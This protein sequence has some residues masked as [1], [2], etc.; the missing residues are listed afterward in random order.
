MT[1]SFVELLASVIFFC[2]IIHTFLVGKFIKLAEQ[3]RE[4]SIQENL[5][6]FFAE[7]EAVFGIWSALFLIIMCF[8]SG[9][10]WPIDYLETLNFTEPA[11]VFVIMAMSGTR[12]VVKLAEHLITA[13]SKLIPVH[14]KVSFYISSM[15]FGPLLGSFITEPAA[16]TVTALII[17]KYFF[18][19]KMSEKFKYATIGLLFVNVSIGGT[20]S[21]FAAPP[22]LM[23]A[24]K[25]GWGL[26]HMLFN[27]GYKGAI[28]CVISSLI[29]TFYFRDELKDP[30]IKTSEDKKLPIPT[31][32]TV[33]HLIF[34]ILVVLTAHH[35]VV[36]S[37]L[38]LFFLGFT[39]VTNEFQEKIKIQE[40][41]MVG[42]FW[43]A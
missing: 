41:L 40:S 2:A 12:P 16:M 24:E 17:L 1:P 29:V 9:F 28:A 20:L 38:F 34:L 37:G 19:Q 39:I 5:F 22:V 36:F 30:I 35:M 23:V 27:F 15:V 14:E 13:V 10:N 42:F 43:E 31:W 6:H 11:F 7:I 32:V 33:T 8:H 4:G 18:S 21:H 25:W 3:Y 26:E